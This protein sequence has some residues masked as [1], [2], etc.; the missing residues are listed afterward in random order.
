[1]SFFPPSMF[2]GFRSEDSDPTI[3]CSTVVCRSSPDAAFLR[4]CPVQYV[5][6]PKAACK[7]GA[8]CTHVSNG[9]GPQAWPCTAWEQ[10]LGATP[11]CCTPACLGASL[12]T[13]LA[14]AASCAQAHAPPRLESAPALLLQQK[15]GPHKD[16][17]HWAAVLQQLC[18]ERSSSG[19]GVSPAPEEQPSAETPDQA[20]AEGAA[21]AAAATQQQQ[22]QQQAAAA[23]GQPSEGTEV[24]PDAA[25]QDGAWGLE[26]AGGAGQSLEVSSSRRAS[27]DVGADGAAAAPAA[28]L[29]SALAQA[30]WAQALAQAAAAKAAQASQP[31]VAATPAGTALPAGQP[32]S[33]AAAPSRAWQGTLQFGDGEEALPVSG[34]WWW[35]DGQPARSAF[36]S[37]GHR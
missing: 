34:N 26:P 10:H 6:D 14:T 1:M 17:N 33:R 21:T 22:Q 24:T 4:Q 18:R 25:E 2:F 19:R 23:E 9:K 11:I 29:P 16:R 12:L 27:R 36:V 35:P 32:S 30:P 13:P 3:C 5:A 8:D 15:S 20:V 28:A 7:G 31:S 37:T